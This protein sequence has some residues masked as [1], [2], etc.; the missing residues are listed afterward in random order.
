MPE[1]GQRLTPEE[2]KAI[3][4]DIKADSLS[5]VKIARKHKVSRNTVAK[6]WREMNG[7]EE[8]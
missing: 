4:A 6:I 7:V 5:D 8:Q 1:R 3:E 2:R